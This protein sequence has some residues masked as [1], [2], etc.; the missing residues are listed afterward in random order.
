MWEGD[1]SVTQGTTQHILNKFNDRRCRITFGLLKPTWKNKIAS[2]ILFGVVRL[3]QGLNLEQLTAQREDGLRKERKGS[4]SLGAEGWQGLGLLVPT[5]PTWWWKVGG[6]PDGASVGDC[7]LDTWSTLWSRGQSSSSKPVM[8][9]RCNMGTPEQP[10]WKKVPQPTPHYGDPD[11]HSNIG[12]HRG[13]DHQGSG[14]GL[15][16]WSLINPGILTGGWSWGR[17]PHRGWRW[18]SPGWEAEHREPGAGLC[19]ALTEGADVRKAKGTCI[20]GRE[21]GHRESQ[22][23]LQSLHSQL[24]RC[25]WWCQPASLQSPEVEAGRK[26]RLH[27][28]LP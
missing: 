1:G 19:P 17:S 27:K 13:G 15:I 5:P 12:S 6:A 9:G 23:C 3:N 21:V 20:R 14:P 10:P 11:L 4:P 16:F 8:A 28:H 7:G 18:R 22:G 24:R 25:S 26:G 2:G